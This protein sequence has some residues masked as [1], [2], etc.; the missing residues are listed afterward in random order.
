MCV[1]YFLSYGELTPWA[2]GV[3]EGV[4]IHLYLSSHRSVSCE[5]RVLDW[6][7]TTKRLRTHPSQKEFVQYLSLVC[8]LL[9]RVLVTPELTPAVKGFMTG[10]MAGSTPGESLLRLCAALTTVSPCRPVII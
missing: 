8:L 10:F 7:Q 6:P 3:E 5:A 9:L 1:F 2:D 4:L